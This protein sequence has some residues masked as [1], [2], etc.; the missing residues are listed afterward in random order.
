MTGVRYLEP[1]LRVT[2][3]Q[4]LRAV[5]DLEYGY[6]SAE[7]HGPFPTV[8]QSAVPVVHLVVT[9][10]IGMGDEPWTIS[11]YTDTILEWDL[12]NRNT[13]WGK[14]IP[15]PLDDAVMEK[16]LYFREW[17]DAMRR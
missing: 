10:L 2:R 13:V 7:Y 16:H 3:T 5:L 9:D 12:H 14:T 15:F 6:Y 17:V 1:Y 11:Y 8:G 4:I